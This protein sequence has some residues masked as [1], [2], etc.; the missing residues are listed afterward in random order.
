VQS[1]PQ[2]EL[3]DKYTSPSFQSVD[4][5]AFSLHADSSK[6]VPHSAQVT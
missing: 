3:R 1:D 4:L 6:I 2:T 5:T